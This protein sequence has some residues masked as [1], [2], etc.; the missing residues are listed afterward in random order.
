MDHMKFDDGT[1]VNA[2][3]KYFDSYRYHA[4]S[5]TFHGILDWSNS[6][7]SKDFDS[8]SCATNRLVKSNKWE[9]I[10]SFSSDFRY[11]GRGVLILHRN[12]C[13]NINCPNIEYKFLMDGEWVIED[14]EE[15][16]DDD[17]Q[18]KNN[19]RLAKV[20]G[21]MFSVQNENGNNMT[22]DRSSKISGF[23][24][25]SSAS[26]PKLVWF[27]SDDTD[28][29]DD[30]SRRQEVS[31][32]FTFDLASEGPAVGDTIECLGLSNQQPK[33]IWR[34]KSITPDDVPLQVIKFGTDEKLL[35]HRLGVMLDQV[36]AVPEFIPTTLWGN[37]FCQA[38]TVGLASYH[39]NED[40]TAYICYEH[41]QT[42]T[43]WGNLD[44]GQPIPPRINFT[45]T[46]FDP[47]RRIFRGT[48]DW[49]GT[50]NTTWHSS[51]WW[52]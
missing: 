45:D 31:D 21:N 22:I 36:S 35:Y 24:D 43:S 19:R 18:D 42:S 30:E 17:A 12:Q 2:E 23:I 28:E 47:D 49:E 50:H 38:G 39:F 29:I 15:E 44:D 37:V 51:R 4:E 33:I 3:K 6:D 9:Y 8:C 14:D 5:R 32:N 1:P 52:K 46:Q 41:E 27:A 7:E 10:L 20:H 25:Y 26:K 40:G 34:R 11:I 13:H 16:D 48:I